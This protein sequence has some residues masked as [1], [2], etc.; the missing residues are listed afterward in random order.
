MGGWLQRQGGA[1]LVLVLMLWGST[2]Q[3]ARADS[4]TFDNFGKQLNVCPTIPHGVCAA[5]AA[6]NS[7]IFLENEYPS[8]YGNLLTPGIQGQKPNQTDPSDLALFGALFLWWGE[9]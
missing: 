1:V 5:A 6:I 9:Q 7:F 3:V 8:I 4:E 2:A